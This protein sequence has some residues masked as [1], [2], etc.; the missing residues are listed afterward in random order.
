MPVYRDRRKSISTSSGTGNFTLSTAPGPWLPITKTDLDVYEF[1]YCI[2]VKGG[3]QWEV[4]RGSML[5]ETTLV[6][7]FVYENSVGGSGPSAQIDFGAGEKDVFLTYPADEIKKLDGIG[8]GDG[9]IGPGAGTSDV[10]ADDT[11]INIIPI[12]SG[13]TGANTCVVELTVL[14]VSASDAKAWRIS[15]II[16]GDGGTAVMHG[17]SVSVIG[18][19]D[20]LPWDVD[21]SLDGLYNHKVECTGEVGVDITWHVFGSPKALVLP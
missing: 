6:R 18:A 4:G 5:D 10:T 17:K 14:A 9:V 15:Y 12:V 7:A 2:A 19:S 20:T 13:A 16:I 3:S 1:P 21:A 11:P 8:I